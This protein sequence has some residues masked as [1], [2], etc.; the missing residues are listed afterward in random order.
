VDGFDDLGVVDSLQVD[1]GDAQVAVAELP[2][3]DDQ[4]DALA[5]HLDGVGVA[6]LMLVPMSAQ[7]PLCRPDC[8]AE[9]GKKVGARWD[10][11]G[12][13]VGITRAVV[14]I[15]SGL[16]FGEGGVDGQAD[17]QG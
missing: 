8:Y 3:D 9:G 17:E 14:V 13:E 11:G 1:G 7:A 5:R 10:V 4:R 2:L 12:V 6:E 16:C 15:L